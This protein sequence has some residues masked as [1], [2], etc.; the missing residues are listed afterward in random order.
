MK[1]SKSFVAL[2]AVFAAVTGLSVA[3]SIPVTGVTR[4]N[5]Q[6][7]VNDELVKLPSHLQ[8]MSQN[9]TTYV[10]LRFLSESMGIN[11]DYKPGTVILD[12]K[13]YEQTS[14]QATQKKITELQAEVDKL[15]SENQ[16]L[17]SQIASAE[18]YVAYRKLPTYTENAR[19]FKLSILDVSKYATDKISLSVSISNTDIYNTYYLDPFAT[20][21]VVNGKEY[22]ATLDEGTN[23]STNLSPGKTLTGSIVFE[24]VD[25]TKIKGA[26]TFYYKTNNVDAETF[27]IFF[28]STK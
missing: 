5:Y 4:V 9:N 17:Q 11:V 20:K 14:T 6:F 12:S 23:L 21:L 22:K 8:V 7:V 28:D 2:L 13:E 18:S 19:G 1:R 24:G 10:P 16:L 25:T 3:S 15:K 27:D 26:A